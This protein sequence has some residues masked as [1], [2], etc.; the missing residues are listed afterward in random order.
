MEFRSKLP[1]IIGKIAVEQNRLI[2][3]KEIEEQT[4]ME[5]RT[6]KGWLSEKKRFSQLDPDSVHSLQTMF[7]VSIDDLVEIVE[8][9]S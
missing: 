1:T 7:N 4:G 3:E 6:I 2:G 5:R 9:A 8:R